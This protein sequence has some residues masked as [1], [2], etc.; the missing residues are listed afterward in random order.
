MSS[1]NTTSGNS[2]GLSLAVKKP[3]SKKRS[4]VNAFGSDEADGD[5]NGDEE[6][7]KDNQNKR[8]MTYKE[9]VNND[10]K[11]KAASAAKK[12]EA[13][14]ASV[15]AE[16]KESIYDYDSFATKKQEEDN[17]K[18]RMIREEQLDSKPQYIAGLM[19]TAKVRGKEKER[20]H[21]KKLIK[22]R[23]AEDELYGDKPK[24]V[25]S[26][27]KAK[28]EEDRKFDEEEEAK[29]AEEARR[30]LSKGM[31]TFLNTMMNG[32]DI[33]SRSNE[34]NRSDNAHAVVKLPSSSSSYD[35]VP[36][37]RPGHG[38]D[39]EKVKRQVAREAEERE[40][41]ESRAAK[42][43][44]HLAQVEQA[45]QRYFLRKQARAS[46]GTWQIPA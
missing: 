15:E 44:E 9:R 2:F 33:I 20:V 38:E 43:K 10:L 13:L 35:A 21:D 3:K 26:A 40:A 7:S 12:V 25:T 32:G 45:R 19:A 42:E 11:E 22:E 39:S 31:G 4:L 27:Y 36:Q 16:G 17:V 24:F 28:L 23:E 34:I 14:K 29:L 5:N 18:R 8:Q 6:E 30:D 41:R 37:L 1:L 46:L